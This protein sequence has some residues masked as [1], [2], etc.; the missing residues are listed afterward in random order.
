MKWFKL[1]KDLAELKSQYRKLAVKLHPDKQTGNAKDFIEMKNEYD[2][3]Y[4]KL[5][6]E[7]KFG[8]AHKKHD[9][10]FG[11]F[12]SIIDKLIFMEKGDIEI[13]GTWIWIH[14]IDRKDLEIHTFLKSLGFQY[15]KGKNAWALGERGK[16]H[17]RG[18]SMDDIR[19]EFGSTKIDKNAKPK[20]P[21]LE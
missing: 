17:K 15:V 2:L 19:N 20:K 12:D 16:F 7:D 3:L 11:S 21:L 14:G 4:K 10:K 18:M 13:N 8:F 5:E 1:V 6:K 9:T